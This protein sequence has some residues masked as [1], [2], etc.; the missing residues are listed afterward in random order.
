MP[1]ILVNGRQK[2]SVP[3][4]GE[5]LPGSAYV[6]VDVLQRLVFFCLFCGSCA[7]TAFSFSQHVHLRQDDVFSASVRVHLCKLFHCPWVPLSM[8]P[9][10]QVGAY[11]VLAKG[12]VSV[13]SHVKTFKVFK[14]LNIESCCCKKTAG[15]ACCSQI[16]SWRGAKKLQQPCRV[17]HLC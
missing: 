10:P 1:G 2:V 13:L 14:H 7:C 3:T 12:E 17:L 5:S 8:A 6:A 15:R 16:T 4:W 9:G 11:L